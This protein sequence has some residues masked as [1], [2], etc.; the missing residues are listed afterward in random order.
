MRTDTTI[1]AQLDRQ[2]QWIHAY[3][4]RLL[5]ELT[6]ILVR[7][8]RG[9]LTALGKDL[10]SATCAKHRIKRVDRFVGNPRLHADVVPQNII[11][12]GIIGA[13]SAK[14]TKRTEPEPSPALPTAQHPR[15]RHGICLCAAQCADLK[16]MPEV[17]CGTE[18]L[19][20]AARR[21]ER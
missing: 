20:Q 12:R 2:F 14:A 16:L 15:A 9:W 18:A 11:R 1:L 5:C 13:V 10:D 8:G 6:L 21:V 3:R 17:R 19:A 7:K 4:R